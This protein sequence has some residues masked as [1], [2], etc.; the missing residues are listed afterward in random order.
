MK[1][2]ISLIT[3]I[4]TSYFVFSLICSFL[5]IQT[6]KFEI[7]RLPFLKHAHAADVLLLAL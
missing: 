5:I 6:I 3:A 4:K 7:L 2:Y 1:K